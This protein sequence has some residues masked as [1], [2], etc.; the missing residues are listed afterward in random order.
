VKH[1]SVF[2]VGLLCMVAGSCGCDNVPAHAHPAPKTIIANG[3]EYLAC[4]GFVT[5]YD[6]SRDIASSSS[7]HMYEIVFTD[8]YGKSMDLKDVTSYTVKDAPKDASYTM[9]AVAT[10]D[11]LSTTYSNG[12][13][14]QQGATVVFGKDG[15]G[16]RAIWNGKGKWS[17]APCKGP[18]D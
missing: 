18:L 14:I 8:D 1:A 3:R 16:G 11:N 12:Q 4:E 9:A 10:S 17:P 2:A 6:P 5:V 7:S 15:D 13:P